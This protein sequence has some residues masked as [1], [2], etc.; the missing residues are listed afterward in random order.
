MGIAT[1]TSVTAGVMGLGYPANEASSTQ[2]PSLVELMANQGT[3]TTK[4]YSLY[5]DSLTSSTGTIL[6]GGV[7]TS[8]Y[9]APLTAL[10]IAPTSGIYKEFNIALTG[11]NLTFSSKNTT[12]M[13][14]SGYSI[15][16]LL[17]SGT[18]LSTLPSTE[19]TTLYS[20]IDA[21]DD[22][23]GSG[24]VY[25]DCKLRT[26]YPDMT[27]N[28]AFSSA[29][30][31]RVPVSE[32]IFSIDPTSLRLPHLPFTDV[33][34]FGIHPSP[35]TDRNI[36][37]D[38]F[39]R[40]AYVVF[41]L[42]N[43]QIGLAQARFGIEASSVVDFVKGSG[44]MPGATQGGENVSLVPS[45]DRPGVGMVASAAAAA[46]VEE[47]DVGQSASTAE[48]SYVS[49]SG[50]EKAVGREGA[51]GKVGMWGMVGFLIGCLLLA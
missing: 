13:T 21:V 48:N 47:T 24:Q 44:T 23:Q 33:C 38:T 17:D 4:A 39:L 29:A 28:F 26:L 27:F 8:K 5:L 18:T 22:T 7:D 31:I 40:S 51:K 42:E 35:T 25:V 43:N 34:V 20:A 11:L 49:S 37:G 15:T 2:Y 16:V 36:L 32:L 41:D 6:F 50:A 30:N 9:T 12:S 19:L 3:I 14:P 45:V 46:G 10:P 1:T